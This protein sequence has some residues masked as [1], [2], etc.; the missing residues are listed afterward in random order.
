MFLLP[1][2][3]AS[4]SEPGARLDLESVNA[5]FDRAIL[6]DGGIDAVVGRLLAAAND[7]DLPDWQR[8]DAWLRVAHLRWRFG[9][10]D[11]ALEAT[12]AALAIRER[13]DGILLK[14]RLL[15]AAG[16]EKQAAAWYERAADATDRAAERE[17]IRLRLTMAEASARNI[18]ALV[19]LAQQ[20]DAD[21]RNRAAITLALLGHTEEA[22][23]LFRVSPATD[24]QFRQHA[25][26]AHWAIHA[27]RLEIAQSEAWHAYRHAD[28]RLDRLYAIALLLESYREAGALD[29]FL[30]R[31]HQA[32]LN[33]EA[34]PDLVQ[35]R[36][37]VLVE[38]ENY[39]AA[40]EFYEQAD[41]SVVDVDARR[42]LIDL[43]EAAGRSDDLVAEYERLMAAEPHVVDWYA[44]LAAHCLNNAESDR[45][46][47]VWRVLAERNPDREPVLMEAAGAP[48]CRWASPPKL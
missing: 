22:I 14:G 33:G 19:E 2:V 27:G 13:T 3:L 31:L 41:R 11:G 45:A 15:D 6:D 28:A 46:L 42:R 12:D 21:F 9:R 25:R 10:L 29:D 37:D 38:T 4:A 44:G 36:V 47:A 5:L 26:L 34:D 48:W 20:R 39:D 24:D 23:A 18:D 1:T 30:A 7:P 35:T 32:M 16:E 43:Y 40:I 8:A 17:F